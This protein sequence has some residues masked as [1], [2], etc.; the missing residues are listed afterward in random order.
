[1]LIYLLYKIMCFTCISE[2]PRLAFLPALIEII[3]LDGLLRA[4]LIEIG[5]YR[6]LELIVALRAGRGFTR[7]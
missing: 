2:R 6:A 1:M 3:L 4:V 5:S 7:W